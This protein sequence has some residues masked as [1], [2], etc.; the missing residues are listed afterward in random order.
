MMVAMTTEQFIHRHSTM[1]LRRAVTPYCSDLTH[2]STERRTLLYNSA[3]RLVGDYAYFCPDCAIADVAF[4]GMA[5]W[6]RSLQVPGRLWCE[7]HQIALLRAPSRALFDSPTNWIKRAAR[8]SDRLL[9]AVVGNEAVIRYFGIA[10]ELM[11]KTT[12]ISRWSIRSI[13]LNRAQKITEKEQFLGRVS[14]SKCLSGLLQVTFPDCWLAAIDRDILDKHSDRILA[15]VDR[16]GGDCPPY[17]V[18]PYLLLSS[19]LYDEETPALRD[20]E[21]AATLED[22]CGLSPRVSRR[23]NIQKFQGNEEPVT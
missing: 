18:W 20:W 9:L 10:E 11:V 15:K 13:L 21:K 4:H 6:R 5:Y 8:V 3:M 2:G 17:T 22:R 14:R 1:P 19:S 7:K 16:V 23:R 12:P